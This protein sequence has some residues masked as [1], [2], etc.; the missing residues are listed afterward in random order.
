MT[1]FE[2]FADFLSNLLGADWQ[3]LVSLAAVFLLCIL[4]IRR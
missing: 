4:V 3:S 2:L 1:L